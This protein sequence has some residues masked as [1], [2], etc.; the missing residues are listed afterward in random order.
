MLL[1]KKVMTVAG[2]LLCWSAL[3]LEADTVGMRTAKTEGQTLTLAAN[4]GVTAVL[5]W[6]NGNTSDF[7]FTGQLQ[8]IP[9]LG[10]SLQIKTTGALLSFYC[11]D[12]ELLTLSL[13][14]A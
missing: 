8:E 5:D 14:M 1:N 4:S 12:N 10:D 2:A 3:P 7:V 9:V 11:A 13:N 6:G